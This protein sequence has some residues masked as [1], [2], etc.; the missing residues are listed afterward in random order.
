MLNKIQL[1]DTTLQIWDQGT[2]SPLLFVHGFPLDHT[3]WSEQ[4]EEFSTTHR[5][6]AVDLRGF[7]GSAP[8]TD[9]PLTMKQHADDLAALLNSLAIDT[10]VTLC[11]LSMGGYVAWQFW[12]HHADRLAAMILCDT[13]AAA[14][15]DEVA[16]GR[17]YLAERVMREGTEQ[18][19]ED[20]L[21]K[22]FSD[23]T[24]THYPQ[25]VSATREVIRRT[26]AASV[27]AAQRG[28]ADRPDMSAFLPNITCPTLVLCGE[29]DVITPAAEMQRMAGQMP[30]SQFTLIS[31]AGHM[32]PLENPAEVNAA[33]RQFLARHAS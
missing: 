30:D 23:A 3:M 17:R 15:T 13:R 27:A 8:V 28:M 25:R 18:A 22:L 7:G 33:M 2:G 12:Q 24:R 29:S 26:P 4:L 16:R 1:A 10:P 11:G 14:D 19:G 5:V 9:A 31:A 6:L 21:K 20:L 32:A